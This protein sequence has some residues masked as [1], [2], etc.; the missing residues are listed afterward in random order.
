[1][2]RD[3]CVTYSVKHCYKTASL[4]TKIKSIILR[5]SMEPK[6]VAARPK[7]VTF[8]E[9]RRKQPA[10][11][12]NLQIV[13]STDDK[14]DDEKE[15]EL[16]EAE[17]LVQNDIIDRCVWRGWLQKRSSWITGNWQ[18]RWCEIRQEKTKRSRNKAIFQY[19]GHINSGTNTSMAA[20]R[21]TMVDARREPSKDKK[22]RACISL[23]VAE[24]KARILLSVGLAT[25]ADALL[26]DIKSAMNISTSPSD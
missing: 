20:K 13:R 18:K 21:L 9:N 25:E 15:P 17:A 26:V 11:S 4:R 14:D 22:G 1:V 12:K 7:A 2:L 19:F 5:A 10:P 6:H 8:G 23:A 3:N 24:R 16:S